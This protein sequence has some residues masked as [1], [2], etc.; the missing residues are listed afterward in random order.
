M[1]SAASARLEVSWCASPANHLINV[2]ADE[3][4]AGRLTDASHERALECARRCGFVKLASVVSE[5]ALRDADAALRALLRDEPDTPLL[6]PLRPSEPLE[7]DGEASWFELEYQKSKNRSS[8]SSWLS[9]LA[10]RS[11]AL[12][13]L[14]PSPQPWAGDA[15]R[16]MVDMPF[17]PPFNASSLARPALLM[18]LVKEL[19]GPRRLGVVVEQAAYIVVGPRTGAQQMHT[20]AA[21]LAA[22]RAGGGVPGFWGASDGNGPA[23]ALVAPPPELLASAQVEAGGATYAL[24]VQ[25]CEAA[26]GL[27]PHLLARDCSSLCSG[28]V[29]R[30][31]CRC[32]TWASSTGRRRSAPPRTARPSAAATCPVSARAAA[33]PRPRR[34]AAARSARWRRCTRTCAS[35]AFARGAARACTAPGCAPAS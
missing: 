18:P 14:A 2:S 7:D 4:A 30:D 29:R 33:A 28:R 9:A 10:A 19:L 6:A 20:D 12:S 16:A 17:A 13:L 25:V 26:D 15:G 23:D 3:R 35:R 24:N 5:A 1:D 34:A 27:G 22:L 32:R 31:S 11:I 8:W 21:H